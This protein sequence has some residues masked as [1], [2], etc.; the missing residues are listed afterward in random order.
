MRTNSVEMYRFWFLHT[1]RM[2][3]ILIENFILIE[4]G[5][6]KLTFFLIAVD[7]KYF[8]GYTSYNIKQSNIWLW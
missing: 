4:N 1:C 2:F 5:R 7:F 3:L 8:N 6:I